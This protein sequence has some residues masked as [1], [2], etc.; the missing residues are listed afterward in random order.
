[1]K[2]P[3]RI[4]IADDEDDIRSCFGRL[5]RKLGYCVVGEASDGQQLVH[6]S[7]RTTPDLIITDVRM[8]NKS[9]LDAAL[10]INQQQAIP[11]IFM[12]SYEEVAGQT[13]EFAVD[14]LLK[15]VD[16]PQL[17]QAICKA[18]PDRCNPH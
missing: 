18:F 3:L 11:V 10:E 7:H 9:G 2:T 1:M 16:V 5:L 8:P 14:F 17:Q 15:P 6:E 13:I 4:V 12:S